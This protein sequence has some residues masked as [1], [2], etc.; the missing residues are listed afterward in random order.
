MERAD[1]YR[2]SSRQKEFVIA[3]HVYVYQQACECVNCFQSE[4]NKREQTHTHS[5]SAVLLQ[6]VWA[7]SAA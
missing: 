2:T 3:L 4:D 1:R 6:S 5:L 7:S